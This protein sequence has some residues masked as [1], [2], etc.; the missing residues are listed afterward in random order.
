MPEMAWL[1][2]QILGQG[3]LMKNKTKPIKGSL[4]V[5][6]DI[7]VANPEET[8]VKAELARNIYLTITKKKLTQQQAAVILDV[9]QPKVSA[10]TNGRLAGFSIE[11]LMRFLNLLGH[12]VTITMSP[13]EKRAQGKTTVTSEI[14]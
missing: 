3:E 1:G 14:H 9:D 11:R 2:A 7:G 6:A 12:D 10:L 13:A 8:L 5:F 4:N